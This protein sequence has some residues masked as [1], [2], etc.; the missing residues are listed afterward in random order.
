[1]NISLVTDY[2]AGL[3]GNPEIKPVTYEEVMRVFKENNDKLRKLLF[4]AIPKISSSRDCIC[5]SA[6]ETAN[7]N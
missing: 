6:L 1:V 3:E 5:S 2:D 7:V 4:K